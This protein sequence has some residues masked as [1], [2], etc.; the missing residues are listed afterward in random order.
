M[1][2]SKAGPTAK[3]LKAGEEVNGWP[4]L[5]ELLGAEG[6]AIVRKVCE[7][8]GI[9]SKAPKATPSKKGYRRLDMYQP[10]PVEAVPEPI[11]KY[12]SETAQALG[13]D[14]AYP[15]LPALAAVASAIGNRRTI[16]LKR[17]W[18]EP[19]I[20]WSVIIGDSGTLKSPAYEKAVACLHRLQKQRNKEHKEAMANYRKE[21][22]KRKK[23]KG[24]GDAGEDEEPNVPTLSR[25]VCSD[26]T[27]EK[28]AAVLDENPAGVLVARDEL[29]GWIGSFTRY[30]GKSGGTDL[31]NWLEMNQAG[32]VIVDRRTG[33]RQT[34]FV[35]RAAVS[36]T[37]GIQPL[38]SGSFDT[39]RFSFPLALGSEQAEDR[40]V[41]ASSG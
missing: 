14:P 4:K 41:F 17:S 25:V 40:R 32:T 22:A 34:I 39:W 27:V 31:P 11:R 10:F 7:W 8:L 5:I 21:T 2:A 26:I 30:K 12:I 23:A 6:V 15:A 36:V 37:G 24:D 13:C 9:A 19:C 38:T 18:E 1:R 3:K 20:L 29:A 28:V 16:R 35:S 33:D